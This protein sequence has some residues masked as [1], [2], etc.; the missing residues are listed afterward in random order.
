M[1]TI[2]IGGN[3]TSADLGGTINGAGGTLNLTGNLTN[4]GTLA[5]PTSGIYTLH[6]GTITGG[7]VNAANNALTFSSTNS[8]LNNVAM[9]GNFSLPA[10]SEFTVENGTSFS[11]NVTLAGNNYIYT[12]PGQRLRS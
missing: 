7:T 2:N 6:G 11:G 3:F 5:Q 10:N 4:S 9:T 12:W 1:S 8:Y